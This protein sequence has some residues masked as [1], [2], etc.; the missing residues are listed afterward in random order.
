MPF[1][2]WVPPFSL[3]IKRCTRACII[4]ILD[5]TKTW[6]C[7]STNSLTIEGFAKI[8]WNLSV[9]GWKSGRLG[10]SLQTHFRCICPCQHQNDFHFPILGNLLV[11]ILILHPLLCIS[12]KPTMG[13]SFSD[14]F[15]YIP[16]PT[17]LGWDL[18]W[19]V[20]QEKSVTLSYT[21]PHPH[22]HWVIS[23]DKVWP[24]NRGLHNYAHVGQVSSLKEHQ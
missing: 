2:H 14:T 8:T 13:I 9:L 24:G 5:D 18:E 20:V 22:T 1:L 6:T 19:R 21:F 12:K 23:S 7:F 3:F 11:S 10:Q 4:Y 15:S 17:P 16:T